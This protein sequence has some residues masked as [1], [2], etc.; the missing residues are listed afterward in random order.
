MANYWPLTRAASTCFSSLISVQHLIPSI[1]VFFFFW[2]TWKM[3]LKL[4]EMHSWHRSYLTDYLSVN[5]RCD[6]VMH[7]KISFGVCLRE[8]DLSSKHPALTME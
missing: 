8:R 1:T 4:R 2:I 5:V 6:F 7:T 3:L